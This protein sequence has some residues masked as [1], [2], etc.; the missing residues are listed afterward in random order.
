MLRGFAGYGAGLEELEAQQRAAENATRANS[1]AV[2]ALAQASQRAA[3]QAAGLTKE[4]KGIVGEFEALTKKGETTADA[5][6]KVGKSLNLSDA[7]GIA[8]AGAALDVLAQRG[9]IAADAITATLGAALKGED[10]G[11]FEAQARAAFDGSEQ[12]VRR[13]AAALD[14]LAEESLRRAGTSTRELATGF[15]DASVSALNDLERPWP[16]R[17]KASRRRPT[18]LAARCRRV[19]TRPPR[20]PARSGLWRL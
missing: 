7:R 14:A 1:T 11:R 17:W 19:W 16:A 2:A 13:L 10:L 12:G 5:L 20:P 4:A 9:R 15:N 6:D 18:K 8:T 3:E